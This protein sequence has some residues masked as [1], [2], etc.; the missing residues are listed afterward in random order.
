MN[1]SSE[2]GLWATWMVVIGSGRGITSAAERAAASAASMSF[3][4][5][6]YSGSCRRAFGRLRGERAARRSARARGVAP[7]QL[8]DARGEDEPEQVRRA[9]PEDGVG[10]G[11]CERGVAADLAQPAEVVALV[12]VER[13]DHLVGGARHR[14]EGAHGVLA[15]R[16]V[17]GHDAVVQPLGALLR[18]ELADVGR[19]RRRRRPA[20][21]PSP[22]GG[23][24]GVAPCMLAPSSTS[25]SA[26][27]DCRAPRSAGRRR[28]R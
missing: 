28:A 18:G 3:W 4:C 8:R 17:L 22:A 5:R 9:R 25:A 14:E 21:R 2:S 27:S 13:A 20:H 19:A 6:R 26:A 15:A 1:A 24:I 23:P 7:L 10:L 16:L 12:E 11:A